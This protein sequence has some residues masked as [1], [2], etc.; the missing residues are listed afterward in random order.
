[1]SGD[2]A[3]TTA[4]VR[5]FLGILVEADVFAILKTTTGGLVGKQSKDEAITEIIKWSDAVS[6]L[7][8]RKVT[9]DCLMRYLLKKNVQF[10]TQANKTTLCQLILKTWKYAQDDQLQKLAFQEDLKKFKPASTASRPSASTSTPLT[11]PITKET[12]PLLSQSNIEGF[13]KKE[14]KPKLDN[15]ATVSTSG[16]SE[17]KRKLEE[18]PC[19]SAEVKKQKEIISQSTPAP[20]PT[21]GDKLTST[22]NVVATKNSHDEARRMVTTCEIGINTDPCTDIALVSNALAEE[23]E[24]INYE[25]QVS[26]RRREQELEQRLGYEFTKWYYERYNSL[27]DFISAHFW[28]ECNLR[29]EYAAKGLQNGKVT[30]FLNDGQ[31]CF[32]ELYSLRSKDKLFFNPNLLTG[33]RSKM[34]PHG[35]VQIMVAGT[36]HQP[37]AT[38][39]QAGLFE[40]MFGLSRDPA[41]DNNYKIKFSMLLFR[42]DS[43][44]FVNQLALCDSSLKG[45]IDDADD[46]YDEDAPDNSLD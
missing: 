22:N 16:I 44:I 4:G 39:R 2:D 45:V 28:G 43:Q 46:D 3:R 33:L 23:I 40:Q 1:M 41:I 8:R 42:E 6:V 9:K 31:R 15:E 29:I 20:L 14:T 7:N 10:S 17:P 26:L 25:N 24:R 12:K 30:E 36:V 35:L 21:D 34:N 32:E 5:E 13:F 19:P 37:D 11:S 27:V 38:G 18:D